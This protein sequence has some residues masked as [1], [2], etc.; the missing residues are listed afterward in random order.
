MCSSG[1]LSPSFSDESE[2]VVDSQGLPLVPLPS[3]FERGEEKFRLGEQTR[4]VL[5]P[6]DDPRLIETVE[7]WASRVR[8]AS[9]LELSIASE[10]VEPGEDDTISFSLNERQ[11]NERQSD[12]PDESYQ[13]VVTADAVEITAPEVPGVF[14]A[15]Q[16]LRQLLP[17]EVEGGSEESDTNQEVS[18]SLPE[19]TIEDKP[20]FA[21][22][23]LHLDVGRHIFPVTFIKK[24][25]D[26]MASYKLN[27]FHWHLTED[28]GWRLE[29]LQYP[30]LT[31]V[32]SQRKETQQPSDPILG[33]G[34]PY[35][36]FYTQDQVREIVE[37]AAKRYVTIVPEIEMPGHSLAALAS[38]PELACTDGPFEVATQWGVFEDIYCPSE[39]TFEFLENVLTEVIELFPGRYIHIGGD[40]VPKQRWENSQTAQ[41]VIE[42]EGLSGEE[43]LQNYF[44]SRIQDFLRE[45]GRQIIGWDEISNGEL[46][47]EAT[48]MSW[49]GVEPGAL[50]AKRG[51]DVV[52]TPNDFLYFDHYQGDPS[53]EPLAF[54]GHTP[55]AEVYRYEPVPSSLD[56]EDAKHILGA[57]GNV[58]TEFM[59][60]SDHVEYMVFPR[61]LA[62]AEVV[63][64]PKEL[65]SWNNFST[66]LPLQLDRLTRRS[67]KYREPVSGFSGPGPSRG[68]SGY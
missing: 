16:T 20:R 2:P 5:S 51:H 26:Q 13:L 34:I 37:Y 58:W 52:M 9:G 30:K 59:T 12:N 39:E 7:L 1:T 63:W 3:Q 14:Y 53:R 36:G 46:G 22:R 55:L 42:R 27:R 40:E 54:E 25:I 6:P 61:L 60:T 19:V 49:R 8:V 68:G 65:R 33:D 67:V 17:P 64:S 62:L 21:Y 23:G 35:G 41:R 29:V 38:Y 47:R 10:S 56:D 28:Q 45:R 18:W 31:E 66:R 11:S 48:V 32:G 57:Q 24:Y 4:L 15:T 44:I 50:A 43:E